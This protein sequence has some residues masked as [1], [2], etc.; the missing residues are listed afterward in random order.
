MPTISIIV[1]VYKVEKYVEK[2]ILSIISQTYKDLEIIL[3]DDGS[4]DNCGRICDE[5]A[6]KDSRIRVIHKENGGLSDARNAGIDVAAGEYIMFV[7]SDDYITG[8]MVE[9]LY[10]RIQSDNSDMALCSYE[11]VDE[12]GNAIA[13]RIDESVIK[14]ECITSR[15]ALEKLCSD[16]G[17]YYVTAWAKL[18]KK[19]LFSNIRFPKGRLH[20]DEFTTYKIIAKCNKISCVEDLM[21]KYVQRNASIMSSM[22]IERQLDAAEAFSERTEFLLGKNYVDIA[23]KNSIVAIGNYRYHYNLSEKTKENK[24]VIRK[25]EKRLRKMCVKL[26][27]STIPFKKKI[28]FGMCI[29]NMHRNILSILKKLNTTL[30]IAKEIYAVILKTKTRKKR[31]FLMYTPVHSNMGDHAIRRGELQFFGKCFSECKLIEINES[32]VKSNKIKNKINKNDLL[33]INGG[34]FL[35]DLW[36]KPENDFKAIIQSFPNNKIIAMPNTA[37]YSDTESGRKLLEEDRGFYAEHKNVIF[38][39]RDK[40]SYDLMTELV[41]SERCRYFPDMALML[42]PEF[43]LQRENILLCTRGDHE[44]VHGKDEFEAVKAE[45]ENHGYTVSYTDTVKSVGEKFAYDRKLRDKYMDSVLREFASAKLVVTERLH[46][47]ILSA[48]TGTPCLAVDNVSKKVSGVYDWIDY[49]DYVKITDLADIDAETAARLIDTKSVYTNGNLEKKFADMAEY[50][51][52]Y[53]AED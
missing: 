33:A 11:W 49:L 5:Y 28:F 24:R 15:E 40:R 39:L 26:I 14:N 7:D 47:M 22:S 12:S 35:G 27:M 6:E 36:M 1:P 31:I 37:Y 42:K 52:K 53:W 19:S 34:G 8:N 13:E 18:Y 38:F 16:K 44:T 43:N 46:G 51:K 48:I 21:Y 3:V 10:N 23:V 29:L 17:W 30:Q 2:C 50:I 45:L 41:G 32:L 20:E 25:I 9:I 4:P